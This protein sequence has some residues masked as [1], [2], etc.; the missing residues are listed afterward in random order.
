MQR[1]F[2]LLFALVIVVAG[3]S[4]AIAASSWYRV[5]WIADGDTIY[6][7]N[8][9]CIR[10]IGVNSPEVAHKNRPAEPYGKAAKRVLAEIIADRPVRLE[11][12]QERRDHYGRTLAHVFD[13]NKRLLSQLMVEKG[14]AHVLFHKK[15]QRYHARLLK[16][17][18]T[19]MAKKNGFWQKVKISAK[20]GHFTG[21]RRSL[22]FHL[23]T[24]KAAQKISRY[25]QLTFKSAWNAFEQ[26]YAPAKECLSGIGYF[27]K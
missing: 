10:F 23:P 19:A 21:N 11:W 2:T 14:L 22:R 26:G 16:S 9:R 27:I 15:N 1:Y 13:Q 4:P 5:R 24:C 3:W 12:D 8:G 7:Q 6:L 18:Q 20:N 25:N 17:Q